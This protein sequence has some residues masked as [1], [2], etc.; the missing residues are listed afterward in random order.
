ML[1]DANLLL[2]ATDRSAPMHKQASH[3]LDAV[4]AGTRRVALPWQSLGAFLRIS[5]NPRVYASPI[6]STQ[7][8]GQVRGWVDAEPTWIPPATERTAV[9]L[10]ELVGRHRVTGDL[11][12]DAMLAALAVEHDLTVMST[13][14]DFARFTEISWENPL[15]R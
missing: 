11:M 7:A 8:W 10:G 9:I 14:T 1:I 13:D 12:P 5:T 6:S 2:Y 15:R 4:L 3:W